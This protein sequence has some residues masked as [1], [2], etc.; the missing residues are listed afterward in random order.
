MKDSSF[1]YADLT[2]PKNV[3]RKPEVDFVKGKVKRIMQEKIMHAVKNKAHLK[4][5]A[6]MRMA[7]VTH[8]NS[9]KAPTTAIVTIQ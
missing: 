5:L 1:F 8:N 2:W 4:V 6:M 9:R 7:I 3:E